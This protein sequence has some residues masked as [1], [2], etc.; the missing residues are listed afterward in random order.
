MTDNS[1]NDKDFGISE[2]GLA[3]VQKNREVFDEVGASAVFGSF[4]RPGILPESRIIQHKRVGN[5]PGI[6]NKKSLHFGPQK[7]QHYPVPLG[8]N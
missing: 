3:R 1:Y 7:T 4:A 5:E 6:T 8:P 2:E